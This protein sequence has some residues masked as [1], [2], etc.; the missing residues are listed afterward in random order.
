MTSSPF[1][2]MDNSSTPPAHSPAPWRVEEGIY[3]L[4][5]RGQPV[6]PSVP[7][8]LKRSGAAQA[9]A[10]II[11]A[12][13]E[14]LDT[15][16]DVSEYL[17][18][19]AEDNPHMDGAI[20]LKADVDALIDRAARAKPVGLTRPALPVRSA[21]SRSLSPF[22]LMK[23]AHTPG[24]W[25]VEENFL[26][27]AEATPVVAWVNV[28]PTRAFPRKPENREI[29]RANARIIAAAPALLEALRDVNDALSHF[30]EIDHLAAGQHFGIALKERLEEAIGRAA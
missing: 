18:L 21:P 6:V 27:S 23:T 17:S 26:V 9:N 4:D 14:L 3:V 10:R 30:Y 12:A 24:P 25:A 29:A 5:A 2:I 28:N 13:P 22:S 1:K 16:R 20:G 7:L 15:L 19:L 11:A 8:R